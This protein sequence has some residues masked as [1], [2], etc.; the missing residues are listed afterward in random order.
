MHESIQCGLLVYAVAGIIRRAPG[1]TNHT[2]ISCIAIQELNAGLEEREQRR[3]QRQLS[4][5][6]DLSNLGGTHEDHTSPSSHPSHNSS[7]NGSNPSFGR[8]S[9]GT[10]ALGGGRDQGPHVTW[11]DTL[12]TWLFGNTGSNNSTA[13]VHQS[14]AGRWGTPRGASPERDTNNLGVLIPRGDPAGN[15]GQASPPS[16]LTSPSRPPRPG[17]A[18]GRGGVPRSVS[19]RV[20]R[21][22]SNGAGEGPGDLAGGVLGG[23]G[24]QES[25]AGAGASTSQPASGSVTPTRRTALTEEE[26]ALVSEGGKKWRWR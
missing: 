17:S 4:S 20:P 13:A 10:S 21:R 11:G 8:S 3:Q 9:K 1:V 18:S 7:H 25:R 15:L 6:T 23:A 19:W 16:S 26:L 2:S 12:S 5:V 22:P 14:E 24:G